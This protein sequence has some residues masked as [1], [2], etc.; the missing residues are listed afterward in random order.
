MPLTRRLPGSTHLI[1]RMQNLRNLVR[2]HGELLLFVVAGI[3]VGG[4]LSAGASQ[5]Q[6]DDRVTVGNAAGTL[7]TIVEVDHQR[8]VIGAGPSRSHTA[9]LLGRTTRPWD[10]EI[11]LLILPGWDDH[12]VPGALGLVE[13]ETV[14]GIAVIGIPGNEPA[15]THLE[16]ETQASGIEFAILDTAGRLPITSDTRIT[17][18]DLAGRAEG[19]W[20]RLDHNGKRVDILDGDGDQFT[21]PDPAALDGDSRHILI[22]TRG[23]VTPDGRDPELLITQTPHWHGDFAGSGDRHLTMINRND[24]LTIT[25]NDGEFRLPLDAVQIRQ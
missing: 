12:H 17:G 19:A 15:W 8:V 13:R 10:R 3:A 22:N 6:P 9:E 4:V 11:D 18:S 23:Y 1:R 5:F 2:P 16:R 25:L 24:H 21:R 20:I 7:V 14:R